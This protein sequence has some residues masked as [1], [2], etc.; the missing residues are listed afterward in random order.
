M[1]R[2]VI[3]GGGIAGLSIAHA[4]RSRDPRADLVVLERGERPGGNVRSEVVDGYTCEWG[5]QGFLDNVPETLRLAEA[6]GLGDRLC[7]SSDAARRRFIYRH[8][9]L[10]EL[11]AGPG[12]FLASRLLS[13]RAKARLA[14]EPFARPRPDGADETIHE[15]ASRRIGVEAASILVDSMVSGVFA[16]D[17]RTLS[18]RACFP[19]MW[20]METEYGGLFRAMLALRKRRRRGDAMGAPAG[21][22][23]SFTGGMEDLVRGVAATLGGALK[24]SAGVIALRKG[25][26]PRRFS[27]W[28][29]A[30]IVD[31]D[32]LV[33]AGPS[34]DAANLLRPHDPALSALLK[35][36]PT[37]P[38][39]VVCLGYDEGTVRRDRG[40]L[41]GFGFLVPR[42]EGIRIL[43]ALWET[44]I[45]PQRRAPE[46]KALVRVM[47]GGARD[48]SAVEL[49]D[50]ALLRIARSDLARTMGLRTGPEFVRIIRHRRGIPQYAAGHLA[51]L[52]RINARLVE[53]P[54]LYLAGNSYRGVSIN[55]CVAEAGPLAGRILAD[56]AAEIV[57]PADT[58][59]TEVL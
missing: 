29:V 10:H 15:F 27:I 50:A 41:D 18:L 40:A 51:R 7:R 48:P 49:D 45:Y 21:T 37:A 11:P 13:P 43:G 20:D 23:T 56:E 8:G 2:I 34:S 16:G 47:I 39:A 25:P 9:R 22:L 54:G 57:G 28:T 19:R 1:T 38:I 53:H 30:G 33:L 32:A 46:G 3:V 31:A 44:S 26:A 5:P 4:I 42:S 24:T 17:A 59:A 36:I 35:G 55:S 12:S 6:V 14:W 52:E 58:E